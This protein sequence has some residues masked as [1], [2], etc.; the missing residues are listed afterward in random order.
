MDYTTQGKYNTTDPYFTQQCISN[1]K[2]EWLIKNPF[3]MHKE[4][5]YM[6]KL[7][8]K[9]K[10]KKNKKKKLTHQSNSKFQKSHLLQTLIRV[11]DS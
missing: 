2:F 7:C 4:I 11:N 3:F 5:G 9:K 1:S 10:Q 8:H 6:I